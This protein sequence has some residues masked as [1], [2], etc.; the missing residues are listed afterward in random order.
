VLCCVLAAGCTDTATSTAQTDRVTMVYSNPENW[1]VFPENTSEPADIIWFYPTASGNSVYS[2]GTDTVDEAMKEAAR[3]A[4][5]KMGS[6]FEGCGNVYVPYYRQIGYDQVTS[7]GSL[8]NQIALIRSCSA[9]ADVFAALDYYFQNCNNG[10]PFIL[11]GHSQ[12]AAVVQIILDEYMKQH[13][14]YYKNM[15]AAYSIGSGVQQKWLDANPHLK[16]A[17]GETDTG[18]IIS[19]NTEAPGATMDSFVIGENAQCINPLTWTTDESYADRSLNKGSRVENADGT[20]TIVPG[21]H[22]AQINKTRGVVIC[23]DAD[24]QVLPV[25]ALL[26]D[27]S[28]HGGDYPLYYANIHENALKR[29]EAFLAN[30]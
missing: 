4:Y 17:T 22:D 3:N 19:W 1:M 26:G 20:V 12:G 8:D 10:R 9:A 14:E 11:G 30:A 23:T 21:L 28:L 24:D 5:D 25:G 6:A 16:L 18:V 2:D 15:I 27:K 29:I 13:P 7:L